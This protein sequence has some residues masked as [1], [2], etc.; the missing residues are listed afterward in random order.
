MK[1][2]DEIV[3]LM[4][5]L[6]KRL[7]DTG[8]YGIDGWKAQVETQISN[9][10]VRKKSYDICMM[11]VDSCK[12]RSFVGITIDAELL[13]SRLYSYTRVN[14]DIEMFKQ[15]NKRPTKDQIL[16]VIHSSYTRDFNVIQA[17][18]QAYNIE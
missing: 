8:V 4:G 10:K 5:D 1:S 9:G 14:E 18:R 6:Q 12:Q 16:N 2:T 13:A 7:N 3:K 11:L 17:L 15:V